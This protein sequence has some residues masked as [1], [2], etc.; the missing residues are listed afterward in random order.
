MNTL[1]PLKIH[2]EC[3]YPSGIR[4]SATR[5]TPPMFKPL[6]KVIEFIGRV[7]PY[8]GIPTRIIRQQM[9]ISRKRIDGM[10]R[11]TFFL[12][13][14]LEKSNRILQLGVN[15]Q[16]IGCNRLILEQRYLAQIGHECVPI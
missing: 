16:I 12:K 11:F 13:M 1:K 8:W 2:L 9:Q 3:G 4:L 15:I 14:L 5:H 10:L 7:L 6:Q